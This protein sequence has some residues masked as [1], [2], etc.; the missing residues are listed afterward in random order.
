MPVLIIMLVLIHSKFVY[1]SE[2]SDSSSCK[3]KEVCLIVT[4]QK[5]L[6]SKIQIINQTAYIISL[7]LD[8]L[9][10]I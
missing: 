3:G 9:I 7:K 4:N 8:I 10:M 6:S 5:N 2:P 1:A